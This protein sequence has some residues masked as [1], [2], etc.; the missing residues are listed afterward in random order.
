MQLWPTLPHQSLV[1]VLRSFQL[2][3]HWTGR[4]LITLSPHPDHL[5]DVTV[6]AWR[7][8][9]SVCTV[10]VFWNFFF[11]CFLFFV[12]PQHFCW[13]WETN[14]QSNQNCSKK[15]SSQSDR[16]TVNLWS[17]WSREGLCLATM[18]QPVLVKSWFHEIIL[19]S[20]LKWGFLASSSYKPAR[21]ERTW[22][23]ILES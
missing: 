20:E 3:A 13:D 15:W 4:H 23:M 22:R 1:P 21:T 10:T 11:C 17:D 7:F 9:I 19:F 8:D 18:R 14:G 12:L 5:S 16:N 6:T 2:L